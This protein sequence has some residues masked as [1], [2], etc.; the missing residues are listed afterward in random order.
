MGQQLS[1]YSAEA[2]RPGVDDLAGLLC[3]PGRVLGFARGRAA[4]L[5]AVLADPWRG[6]A[7]VAALAERGV[8]AE[9]GAPEPVGDPE[10]PA[11][12][13]EPGAQPPVQVRTP[14]RTDLAP[15]AAHWLLAGAKVV[16]SGFTP[17]GGVLRLWALTS[18]RWVE[19]GYLLGL[20][21][22]APDTHEPLRAALASA[23]LP[24]ALLTPK[25]GGPA[26]RVTGRRR[27]ERLSELVGRAPT[28]V[29]DRTW[30]AA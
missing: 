14:F 24:A 23:G 8:Q 21:P 30:P 22:D 13:Q 20:D 11:A 25:S 10:P 1:F 7:L 3:G 5:T 9:S 18:G 12:G 17:H 4:R 16:P 28:G 29:G 2:R 26:L 15:L 27:L 19:P 6:P